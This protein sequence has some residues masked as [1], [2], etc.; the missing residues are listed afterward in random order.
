M[1]VPWNTKRKPNRPTDRTSP[2]TPC[3]EK[4]FPFPKSKSPSKKITQG[5]A[6]KKKKENSGRARWDRGR[7]VSLKSPPRRYSDPRRQF[8]TEALSFAMI[9]SSVGLFIKRSTRRCR[10]V[11]RRHSKHIDQPLIQRNSPF[12]HHLRCLSA[13]VEVAA[14]IASAEAGIAAVA[15][16][17]HTAAAVGSPGADLGKLAVG[18]EG[19]SSSLSKTL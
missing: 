12:R 1:P 14:H 3:K 2:R 11:P 19:W 10:I 7:I 5:M 17:R 18:I 9:C 13:V 6:M 4:D 8:C 15:D 16:N